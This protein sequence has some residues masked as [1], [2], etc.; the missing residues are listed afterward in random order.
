M[1]NSRLFELLS[2]VTHTDLKEIRTLCEVTYI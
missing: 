2:V 1:Q